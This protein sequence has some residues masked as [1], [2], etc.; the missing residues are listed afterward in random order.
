MGGVLLLVAGLLFF[1]YNIYRVVPVFREM[2][3]EYGDSLSQDITD[4]L[5]GSDWSVHLGELDLS[6]VDQE[7]T[8]TYQLTVHHG[9]KEFVYEVTIQDTIAPEII[10]KE[11]R[12]YLAAGR[13]CTVEDVIGGVSDVD[14]EARAYFS[15][16]EEL[17]G[18]IRFEQAGNYEVEVLA[19]DSAGNETRGQVSVTVDTAPVF[20][21][22]HDFYCVPG[23]LPD[24]LED[25][26]AEDD[27]DGDLTRKIRVDDGEV[28][29][30]KNGDYVLRYVVQDQYGLE[31][32]EEARV[33]VA[34]PDEIQDLIGRRQIDYR[35][36]TILGAPN[37]YDAGAAE[38]EN[39]DETLEY[40]RPAFVQLYHGLG[41]GGYSS[42]SG[43]IMEITDEEIYICSN[44]HVVGKY[45][46]WDVY[47]FDGTAV[48]GKTLGTSDIF[49]VGVAVVSLEDVPEELLEQLM[50]VH[51]DK[52]Y[53]DKLDQQDIN[54][55]LE[56]IDRKGG[57]LH[58]TRGKL[59]KVRQDFDWQ[60]MLQHTE[61]TVE[62]V[63]GDSGSA[64]V[65]GYGNLIC[66]AYAYSTDPV[67][68]WCVPL[69]GILYCYWEIT[70]RALYVY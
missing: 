68:Y 3:C 24:Y 34:A 64:V 20:S 43:Y 58:T 50:T 38:Y 14:P 65:D 16:G 70:G 61:V 22:I 30:E 12:V 48:P 39:M 44:S 2:T 60:G 18:E 32:V 26:G 27:L 7:H 28:D 51:I 57:I 41:R 36:D 1:Y 6:G 53:W 45:D 21:G 29:L 31:T 49:D 67:R 8:G 42:G 63:H 4:Y 69:D 33:L 19:R 9:Q 46:Q 25:I 52:T 54:L 23:S 11:G 47:F 56:R 10:W 17:L 5:S 40:M 35:T 62:P 13:D 55:A 66:M 37:I 15:R 59:V